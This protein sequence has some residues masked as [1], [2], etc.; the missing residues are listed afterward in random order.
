M[1]RIFKGSDFGIIP[2]TDIAPA[3]KTGDIYCLFD[4]RRKYQG[5]FVERCR[6]TVLENVAQHFNYGLAEKNRRVSPRKAARSPLSPSVCG[7]RRCRRNSLSG[8]RTRNCFTISAI[9]I[10]IEETTTRRQG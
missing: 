9:C 2:G 8:D 1:V 5:I 6:D 3:C 4:V 7:T 10:T